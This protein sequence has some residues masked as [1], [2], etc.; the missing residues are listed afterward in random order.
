MQVREQINLREHALAKMW[1]VIGALAVSATFNLTYSIVLCSL[2]N[3][4]CVLFTNQLSNAFLTT[5]SR[6]IQYVFWLL[7]V[8]CLFWPATTEAN[9]FFRTCNSICC[10]QY[11]PITLKEKNDTEE[12]HDED[13]NGSFSNFEDY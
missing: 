9:P 1:F 5:T 13:R 6:L 7:P 3:Q 12:V 11:K 8:V 4:E 2:A 10:C